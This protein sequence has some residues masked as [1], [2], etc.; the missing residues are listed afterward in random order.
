MGN[1][2]LV[3]DSGTVW[4]LV[5]KTA[6]IGPTTLVTA[7]AP[8]S[9]VTLILDSV[10]NTY[11]SQLNGQTVCQGAYTIAKDTSYYDSQIL[12]LDKFATTGIFQP[13]IL[14]QIGTDGQILSTYDGWTMYL[15]A[16]TMTL[17]SALTPGGFSQ[18]VF[19]K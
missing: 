3:L 11:M 19:T 6:S 13:F 10:T 14:Y 12:T 8:D 4:N 17:T 1:H 2:A 18:Y 9:A 5:Q 16:D 7:P 15:R